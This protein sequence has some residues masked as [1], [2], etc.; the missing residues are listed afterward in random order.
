MYRN[1]SLAPIS[2]A[3][4]AFAA[5][6]EDTIGGRISFAR[7]ATGLSVAHLS[8]VVGVT[9]RTWKN[10]EADRAEPRANRLDML[11]RVL[12]VNITW[13]ISGVGPEPRFH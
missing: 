13:L 9:E 3:S 10:W 4:A 2:A 12:G 7:D 6:A 5:A 11:A 1:D 8:A